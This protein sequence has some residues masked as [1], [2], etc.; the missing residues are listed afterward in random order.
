M[1]KYSYPEIR[2]MIDARLTD[3]VHQ[4]IE[5]IVQ[6]TSVSYVQDGAKFLEEL[7]VSGGKRVR[8]YALVQMYSTSGGEDISA[9]IEAAVAIELFHM[10]ALIHDDV[11]D[12]A[13]SRRGVMTM[14]AVSK[15]WLTQNNRRNDFDH[16]ANAQAIL[17]GD[18]LLA[19]SQGKLQSVPFPERF[20]TT[21][22]S[23]FSRMFTE[24][25]VGEMIDVDMVTRTD[26]ED[27]ELLEKTLLK[28]AYYSFIRPMQIGVALAG[29]NKI[30]NEFCQ[31]FGEA[32][33]MAFQIQ[34][35]MFDL[36]LSEE[37]IQKPVLHDIRSGEHTFFTQF[38]FNNGTSM[39]K[40]LLRSFFG[41]DIPNE[42]TNEVREL[43][44]NSGSIAYGTKLMNE[45]FS[46]AEESLSLLPVQ[47]KQTWKSLI[48]L[49]KSRKS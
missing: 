15:K 30:M 35:D 43:F 6:E 39:Q 14:H 20:R 38:V 36:V 31:R 5:T 1:N 34:D 12:K 42:K 9:I 7:I 24:V 23:I 27:S 48:T 49:I 29:G 18:L 22:L 4:I 2:R 19:V 8:G 17:W 32:I 25:V 33:G 40:K 45:Y 11:I 46:K 47:E 41:H 13:D 37:S 16:I 21:A 44:V 10:F 26:V 3:Y 28:T